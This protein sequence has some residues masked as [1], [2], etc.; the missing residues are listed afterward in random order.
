MGAKFIT[1]HLPLAV[2]ALFSHSFLDVSDDLIGLLAALAF[3]EDCL[4]SVPFVFDTGGGG[5][6]DVLD[7][8]ILG[9]DAC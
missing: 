3:N 6:D 9:E 8:I 7:G 2:S 4:P 5:N 1:S